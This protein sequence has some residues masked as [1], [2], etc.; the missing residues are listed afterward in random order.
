LLACRLS[1]DVERAADNL[2]LVLTELQTAKELKGKS[3]S[4][5]CT[6]FS[7]LLFDSKYRNFGDFERKMLSELDKSDL[8]LSM[9]DGHLAAVLRIGA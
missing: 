6:E 4:V 3:Y 1:F 8:K 5:K 2:R 7:W 9:F